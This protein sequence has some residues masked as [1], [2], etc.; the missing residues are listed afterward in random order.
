MRK[1]PQKEIICYIMPLIMQ[2]TVKE[3]YDISVD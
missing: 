2:D 3:G 1:G